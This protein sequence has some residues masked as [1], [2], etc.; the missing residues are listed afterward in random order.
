MSLVGAERAT[1][2]LRVVCRVVLVDVGVF[3]D[4]GSGVESAKMPDHIAYYIKSL[5][6]E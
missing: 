3:E 2:E 1:V 6:T 5:S 4:V